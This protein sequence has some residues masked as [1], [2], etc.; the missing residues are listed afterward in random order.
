MIHTAR[1]SQRFRSVI[2]QLLA[3]IDPLSVDSL[4]ALMQFAP[5]QDHPSSDVGGAVLVTIEC[6]GSLLSNVAPTSSSLPVVPLHTSFRD[7]LADQNRSGDFYIRSL[8]TAHWELTYSS[9]RTM[10]DSNGLR[11]N[12]CG[13]ETSYRINRDIPDLESLIAENIPHHLLYACRFWGDHLERVAFSHDLAE[14]VQSLFH[15][16]ILFWL[17]V[18][19]LTGEIRLASLALS[20]ATSW[21][22]SAPS[23]ACTSLKA[24]AKD[25]FR[26]VRY[27]GMPMAQ[28]APHIYLS[29]LPFAPTSSPVFEC[30]IHRFSKMLSVQ[31]G[32]LSHWPALEMVIEAQGLVFSVA[33]SPDGQ[34]IAS[35]SEDRTIRVWD[36]ATGV[37]VA[38]PFDGHTDRVSGID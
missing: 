14:K 35:G 28:S 18:L 2:G 5:P 37:M 12:I 29:A 17:E 11:F 34:R 38:G 23:D 36:A 32:R 22:A 15:E 7:F 6:M 16:K 24:L 4:I 26:F 21:L 1:V 33:F 25:T 9:L 19:S 20:A 27:F 10:L 30:Y 31:Q 13:L 8:D 3:A